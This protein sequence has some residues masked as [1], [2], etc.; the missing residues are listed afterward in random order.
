MENLISVLEQECTE[1]DELLGLSRKKTPIIVKGDLEA[2]EQ[3]TDEEQKVVGRITH[4]E[5]QRTQVIKDI[6]NVM[7]KDVESLKLTELI[8]LMESRPEESGKLALL[9]DRLTTVLG[10]MQRV[11]E[12]NR[13]LIAHSLEMVEFD[14]NLLH[15]MKAAPETANYNKGAYSAGDVM[16]VDRGSFDAKS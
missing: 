15:A 6:A 10:N 12:Q 8:R 14:I 1:Y 7:N 13:D 3:I 11:N 5:N 2:L 16:G 4:L 9:H